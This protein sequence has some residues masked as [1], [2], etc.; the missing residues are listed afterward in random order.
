VTQ[1]S[2]GFGEVFYR[3]QKEKVPDILSDLRPSELP[4]LRSGVFH[5]KN[6]LTLLTCKRMKSRENPYAV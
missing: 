1:N 5:H 3:C 4:E 6:S 2:V